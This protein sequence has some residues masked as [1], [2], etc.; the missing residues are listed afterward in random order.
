[1]FIVIVNDNEYS[2]EANYQNDTLT[3]IYNHNSYSVKGKWNLSSYKLFNVIIELLC[4]RGEEEQQYISDITVKVERKDNKYL[5]KHAGMK[6][7]CCVFHPHVAELNKLMLNNKTEGVLA[8]VVQSPIC[9]LL[10]K[11]HVNVGDQIEI[12]QPLF[13]V[14]AMKMEN[15]ICS[16]IEAVIKNILVHEGE[17]IQAGD[18]IL[19]V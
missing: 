12:G 11:L 4:H 13:V 16:E 14:E 10:A 6:T 3:A 15:I 7:E 1:M 9:G 2:I 18:I 19:N 17:S 5:L 8:N